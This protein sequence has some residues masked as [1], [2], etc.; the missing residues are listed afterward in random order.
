MTCPSFPAGCGYANARPEA[1]LPK[2]GKVEFDG[3]KNQPDDA[4]DRDKPLAAQRIRSGEPKLVGPDFM[5]RRHRLLVLEN[6]QN[7]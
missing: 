4:V 7:A 5:P 6:G 1:A 2:V 3:V